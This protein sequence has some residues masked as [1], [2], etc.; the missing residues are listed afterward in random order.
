MSVLIDIISAIVV[1]GV[2]ILIAL[3]TTDNGT[4]EMVNYNAA[5]VVQLDLEQTTEIIEQD[6]KKIGFGI[7][8]TEQ[9]NVFQIAQEIS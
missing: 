1:G 4:Q 5:R 8:E 9:E 7:P 6:I 2:L 3:V